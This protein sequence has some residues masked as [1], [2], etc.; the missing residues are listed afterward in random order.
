MEKRV[1]MLQPP[2]YAGANNYG[3]FWAFPIIM[4]NTLKSD[5]ANVEPLRGNANYGKTGDRCYMSKL[6]LFFLP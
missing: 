5:P 2:D 4:E 6:D 1:N 3:Q